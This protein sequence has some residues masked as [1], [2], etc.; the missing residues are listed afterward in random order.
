MTAALRK[1]TRN[2]RKGKSLRSYIFSPKS[3]QL[4]YTLGSHLWPLRSLRCTT[5]RSTADWC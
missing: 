3:I 2:G 5:E 1:S 4:I